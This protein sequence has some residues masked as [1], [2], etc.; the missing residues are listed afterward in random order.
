[1]TGAGLAYAALPYAPGQTLDPTCHPGE[2]NCTV[3][4]FTAAGDLSGGSTYQTVVGLQGNPIASTT[5]TSSQVLQ[6]NGSAWAPA[7]L[8]T[9]TSTSTNYWSPTSTGIYYNA[10]GSVAVGTTVHVNGTGNIVAALNTAISACASVGCTIDASGYVPTGTASTTLALNKPITLTLP[11]GE[12]L[13]SANPAVAITSTGV[14]LRGAGAA[15]F[16]S[17][18]TGTVIHGTNASNPV[19]SIGTSAAISHISVLDMTL[20]GG[21]DCISIV[22][23]EPNYVSQFDIQ[24]V[25]ATSCGRDGAQMSRVYNFVLRDVWLNSNGRYGLWLNG[26]S[27]S[28]SEAQVSNLYANANTSDQVYV[29]GNSVGI[30][31]DHLTA[32]SAGGTAYGLHLRDAAAITLIEPW[33]EAN[34]YGQ[35]LAESVLGLTITGGEIEQ[36]GTAKGLVI[37]FSPTVGFDMNWNIDVGRW[38][39]SSSATR[40]DASVHATVV[41]NIVLGRGGSGAVAGMTGIFTPADVTG[42]SGNY[43]SPHGISFP[44]LSM[45]STSVN[46]TA[47]TA[48][49][50]E[51]PSGY[52]NIVTCS[53]GAYTQTGTAQVYT[54]PANFAYLSTP[55]LTIA[56]GSC[57]TYNP[58]AAW[59]KVTFPA[60]AG[61]TAETCQ[62]TVM[63]Q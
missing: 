52:L 36:S 44:L 15:V 29:S 16:A 28:I 19:I 50:S 40:I 58:T 46:G 21:Q 39:N 63:G 33:F 53:L 31:F 14:I 47:G 23:T 3:Q 37:G 17:P 43:P 26:E 18:V 24:R 55:V 51:A 38:Y 22:P 4:V 9:S 34:T 20:T 59:D 62:F 25:T 1:M 41:A 11:A 30:L 57:G 12:I 35:I 32:A 56:G 54:Y 27:N 2:P 60:N 8:S 13:S 42:Y 61:M 10:S 49:C 48:A 7:T 45:I 5:P 6:W